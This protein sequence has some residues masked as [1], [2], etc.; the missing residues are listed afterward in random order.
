M[1]IEE[2]KNEEMY[3][4]FTPDGSAQLTTLAPDFPMC[5]AMIRMLHKAGMGESFHELLKVKGFMI[6]PVKVTIVQNGDENKPF[7][8]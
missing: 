6:M 2:L 7:N 1:K 3:C 8:H 4:L 5:V